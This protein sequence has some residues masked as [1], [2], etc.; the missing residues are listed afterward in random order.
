MIYQQPAAIDLE[1][2]LLKP[3]S[4]FERCWSALLGLLALM[5]GFTF[6]VALSRFEAR[7]DAVLDEAN[8][9]G[10][11]ALRASG[12]ASGHG[13]RRR[14]GACSS[15]PSARTRRPLSDR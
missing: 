9:I 7:L 15:A 4:F 2:V 6:S 3:A 8:A 1:K 14:A 10:T 11:T 5:M 13:G 12:C